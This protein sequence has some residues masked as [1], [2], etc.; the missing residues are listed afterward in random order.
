[1]VPHYLLVLTLAA[2]ASARTASTSQNTID[3]P[4]SSEDSVLGDLKV[5]YETYKD[6]SG[7]ELAN[8]LKLKLAKALTRISKSDELSLL[9]GVT[10]TK[11]KDAQVANVVEEAVPRGL[12]E[13]SMDNLIMDKIVGFMQSHTIQVRANCFPSYLDCLRVKLMYL[14][15]R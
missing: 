13:S 2:A 1:M 11:D 5:A 4:R 12:D 8:C 6:C 3:E 10:I 9:G 7:V 15:R 14:N